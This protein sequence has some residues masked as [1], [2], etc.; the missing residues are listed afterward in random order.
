MANL[1]QTAANVAAAAGA[2]IDTTKIAGAT[3]TAG[4]P[5]YIDAADGKAK[6]ADNNVSA[7]LAAVYGIAL[8]GASDGQPVA[9]CTEGDVN[10]GATLAIGEI[11]ALSATAGAICP[12]ADVVSTNFVSH[13]GTARTPALM[14]LKI[15][16][17]G[18]AHA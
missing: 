4:M 9:I 17:T 7:A 12:D 16:N 2:K 10:L 8:N 18:V 13:L 3:L 14:Q 15:N 5:V 11:Y 1:S 6:I